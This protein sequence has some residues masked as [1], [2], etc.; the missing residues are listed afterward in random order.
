MLGLLLGGHATTTLA[1]VTPG[2]IGADQTV[3]AGGTPAP[4]ASLMAAS[5]GTGTYAYQWESSL[6]NFAWTAIPGAAGAMYEP[7]PLASTTYFRRRVTSGT[8]SS[9]TATSNTVMVIMLPTLTAGSIGADQTLFAG[10]VPAS[11]TSITGATGGTGT[12]AYQWEASPDGST[13]TVI[14]G[15]S[16]DTFAPGPLTFTTYFRRRVTSGVCAPAFSSVVTLVVRPILASRAAAATN[17]FM[18]YPNP[19]NSGRLHLAPRLSGPGHA[20]LLNALGQ[21]VLTK[22][23]SGT[24]DQTIITSGLAPGV[25]TLRVAT[26]GRILTRSV[27]L[28]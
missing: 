18:V 2:S 6:D 16:G 13:W 20:T 9:A 25:Y 24:E 10:T 21:A 3:C 15:A 14:A 4:L 17:A 7:G 12:Y 1:Q 28:E 23:L 22:D 26:A 19:S 8:G 5:G 11:L 27:A